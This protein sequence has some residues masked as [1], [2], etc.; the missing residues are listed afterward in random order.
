M[1]SRSANNANFSVNNLFEASLVNCTASWGIEAT[2]LSSASF[3][4]CSFN[5]CTVFEIQKRRRSISIARS[6]E[7]GAVFPFHTMDEPFWDW[8]CGPLGES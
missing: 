5:T 8:A 1:A 4:P 6:A 2:L 7:N 3:V